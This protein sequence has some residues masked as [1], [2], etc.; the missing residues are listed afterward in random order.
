MDDRP[1]ITA[2]ELFVRRVA[3]Q[4]DEGMLSNHVPSSGYAAGWHAVTALGGSACAG[5][6][7][8][9]LFISRCSACRAIVFPPSGMAT[10]WRV[11][12]C[13]PAHNDSLGRGGSD[14]GPSVPAAVALMPSSLPCARLGFF[15]RPRRQEFAA[16]MVTSSQR[17][18]PTTL[19]PG[20]AQ[21][22]GIL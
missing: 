4:Y 7:C 15:H 1:H 18:R 3:I 22:A 12:P 10:R 13:H 9:L 2:V 5:G 17:G 16:P 14:V 20:G 11:T 21:P 19:K 6:R 8:A